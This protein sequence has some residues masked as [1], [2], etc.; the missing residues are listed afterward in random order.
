MSRGNLQKLKE[1]LK[2]EGDVEK[3]LNKLM[4]KS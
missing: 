4:K 3:K 1:K 2:L